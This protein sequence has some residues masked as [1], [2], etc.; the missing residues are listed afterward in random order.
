[1]DWIQIGAQAATIIIPMGAIIS[2][3]IKRLDEKFDKI[4]SKLESIEKDIRNID[5]RVSMIEGFLMG[6]DF[7]NTGSVD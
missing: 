7:R 1:M 4:D 2:W 3:S 6:R 5:R